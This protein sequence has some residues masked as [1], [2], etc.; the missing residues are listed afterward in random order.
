MILNIYYIDKFTIIFIIGGQPS[1]LVY[2]ILNRPIDFYASVTTEGFFEALYTVF[3]ILVIIKFTLV[4]VSVVFS[5]S[6]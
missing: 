4:H 6:G 1:E 3:Y 2:I 5:V